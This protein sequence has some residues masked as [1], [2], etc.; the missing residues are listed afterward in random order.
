MTIWSDKPPSIDEI[1]ANVSLYWFTKSYPTS[2]WVYRNP[3]MDTYYTGSL[4]KITKPFGVSWFPHEVSAPPK[5]WADATGKVTFWRQ[6]DRGGHFAALEVPELLWGDVEEMLN[7][8][9]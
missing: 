8:V 3:G 9:F 7:I 6:H 5:S 2:I 1:L 4:D